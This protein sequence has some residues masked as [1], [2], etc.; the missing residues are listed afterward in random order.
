MNCE[1]ANVGAMT[2]GGRQLA[3][4]L[5]NG[6]QCKMI[7]VQKVEGFNENEAPVRLFGKCEDGTTLLVSRQA[8]IL[9]ED[10]AWEA[11]IEE[12]SSVQLRSREKLVTHDSSDASFVLCLVFFALQVAT[13]TAQ[14]GTFLTLP[15]RSGFL[16]GI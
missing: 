3:E 8:G 9:L 10:F 5:V 2:V 12:S 7:H 15:G 16:L 11:A 1:I 4:M 13:V 6:P 14:Y